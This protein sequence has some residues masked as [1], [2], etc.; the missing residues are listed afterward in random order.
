MFRDQAWYFENAAAIS[1]KNPISSVFHATSSQEMQY[2]FR[3]IVKKE[4][5]RFKISIIWTYEIN[6][7]QNMEQ[8]V[9]KMEK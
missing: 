6:V 7:K 8:M 1:C 3:N 4:S 5:K 2:M 9:C